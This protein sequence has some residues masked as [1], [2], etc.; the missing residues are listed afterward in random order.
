MLD[1][2][3]LRVSQLTDASGRPLPGCKPWTRSPRTMVGEPRERRPRSF[4]I[5]RKGCGLRGTIQRQDDRPWQRR[6]RQQGISSSHPR[7]D[8]SRLETLETCFEVFTC[9]FRTVRCVEGLAALLRG[10]RSGVAAAADLPHAEAL[11]A[12]AANPAR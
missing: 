8:M 10:G 4:P 11:A 12:E 3:F 1:P 7:Q 2:E 9:V 6:P 5:G